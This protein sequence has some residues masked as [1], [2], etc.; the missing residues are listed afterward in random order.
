MKAILIPCS[1]NIHIYHNFS[2]FNYVKSENIWLII[3]MLNDNPETHFLNL[4]LYLHK[5]TLSSFLN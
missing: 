1:D 2:M 3:R 4:E 5:K